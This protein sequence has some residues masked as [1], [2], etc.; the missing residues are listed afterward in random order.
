MKAPLLLT[1]LALALIAAPSILRS[2]EARASVYLVDRSGEFAATGGSCLPY[3]ALEKPG[4]MR[5]ILS[6]AK[7]PAGSTVFMVAFA[8]D[9][10]HLGLPPV[11]AVQTA[12]SK[13]LRFPGEGAKWPYESAA[14]PVDL[15]IAIFDQADPELAKLTEYA[16]WLSDAL[17]SKNET[18]ILLHSEVIKKR[19]NQLVRQQGGSELSSKL[20]GAITA[21]REASSSKAAT[22]R[23]GAT[24]TGFPGKREAKASIAA[25]RRGLNTLENEWREDSRPIAFE[26]AKPGVLVI[27]IAT[28]AAP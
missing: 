24:S 19:L 2:D 22:T 17:K 26:R 25:V 27:P 18:E 13:P 11:V 4:P 6:L 3:S 8:G 7:G 21:P 15:Y 12:D 5:E 28:A 9:T 1:G 16:T 20:G 14:K 23:G 10:P